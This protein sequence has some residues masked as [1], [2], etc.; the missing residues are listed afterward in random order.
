[1]T[2]N[3]GTSPVQVDGSTG[4]P[5]TVVLDGDIDPQE[6][7]AALSEAADDEVRPAGPEPFAPHPVRRSSRPY[8][9]EFL[10]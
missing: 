1:M 10:G 2:I 3:D 9:G 8:A 6:V 5:L 4:G 7:L